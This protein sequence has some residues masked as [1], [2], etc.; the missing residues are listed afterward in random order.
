MSA[1]GRFFRRFLWAT[2]PLRLALVIYALL[3]VLNIL[4]PPSGRVHTEKAHQ[5][6]TTRSIRYPVWDFLGYDE[7]LAGRFETVPEGT[8]IRDYKWTEVDGLFLGGTALLLTIVYA[9]VV[10]GITVTRPEGEHDA[11]GE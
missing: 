11:E 2:R 7:R 1:V 3:M 8:V 9:A 6:L 5:L 10:V 4:Y